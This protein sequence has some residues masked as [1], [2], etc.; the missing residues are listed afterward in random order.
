[1]NQLTAILLLNS[2]LGP[3]ISI[4]CRGHIGVLHYPGIVTT[5]FPHL[6][7]LFWTGVWPDQRN[8]PKLEQVFLPYQNSWILFEADGSAGP[9][10]LAVY[11]EKGQLKRQLLAGDWLVKDWLNKEQ[12][13]TPET[14]YKRLQKKKISLPP[15]IQEGAHLQRIFR[16]ELLAKE[17]K[18]YQSFG[19]DVIYHCLPAI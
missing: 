19:K 14:W 7:N 9:F 11:A 15:L 8:S 2:S 5:Y 16:G 12:A 4:P 18:A 17:R 13:M 3:S 10:V 6:L 1:M